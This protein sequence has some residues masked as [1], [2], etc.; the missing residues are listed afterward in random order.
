MSETLKGRGGLNQVYCA[1]VGGL[2]RLTEDLVSVLQHQ[3][4]N[5]YLQQ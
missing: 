3:S 5:R 1:V 2:P 4:V